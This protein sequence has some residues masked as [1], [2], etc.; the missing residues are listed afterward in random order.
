MVEESKLLVVDACVAINLVATRRWNEI[1]AA[2]QHVPVMP[3]LALQEVLYL[4]DDEGERVEI[5]LADLRETGE[6]I[7]DELR[8]E[9]VTLVLELAA[10][11]GRGEAAAIAIARSKGLSLATDDRL[12]QNISELGSGR[13]V[14]TSALIR[15]WAATKTQRR[16]EI[17]EVI[18]LI[19]KRASFRP[20][21]R[22][23]HFEWWNAQRKSDG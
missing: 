15:A 5:S 12:A 8:P 23:P 3:R 16:S 22:D 6:L 17:V 18:E 7:I 21:R 10:E 4:F 2:N 14:T 1:F 20:G 9:Q 19:E 11:V 13:L